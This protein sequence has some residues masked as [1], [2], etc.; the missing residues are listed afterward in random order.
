MAY[1]GAALSAEGSGD[2]LHLEAEPGFT[3]S[4]AG[5][6]GTS[7]G[8][9][10]FDRH[11]AMTWDHDLAGPGNVALMG[12]LGATTGTLALAFATTR[13]GATT[14]ARSALVVGLPEV[15][16]AALSGWTN[17][18][19]ELRLPSDALPANLAAQA[20]RAAAVLKAHE[21]R[22][23]PGAIVA[24]L[25]I[26]WGNAHDDLGGYHLV[27]ARDAVNSGLG[28]LA[29][30][31]TEDA[32]RMLSYLVAMQQLDGHWGQNFY[33]DG[34][35]Y[36][37]GIQMDEVG[38]PVILATKLLEAGLI[39]PDGPMH[40]HVQRM[41]ERATGFI[42]R[43]GPLTEQDRWEEN[44]GLNCYSLSVQV[45][46]LVAA[47]QW[48]SGA[49]RDLALAMADDWNARMED[50]TF[51]SG[52][53]LDRA[54]DIAG[55]YVRIV[56]DGRSPP[57]GQQVEVRNRGGLVTSVEDLVALDFLSLA[58]F[59]LRPSD[60]P[61]LRDTVKLCDALLGVDTPGGHSFYRYNGDG[62][63]EHANG[64]PFDG[65]GIG[66]AWPLLTGE[67]GHFAMQ[68]GED[69]KP[70]LSAMASMTGPGGLIPEQVWEA[71]ALPDRGLRPGKP[72]GA[73]M[74]LV[75]AHSEYL[76]LAAAACTGKP[77][78]LL[79]CVA[80]RYGTI[81]PDPNTRYWRDPTPLRQILQGTRLCVMDR[82]PFAL[83]ASEDDWRTT[84]D[85]E[86]EALPFGIFGATVEI[87][88][89][90]T[91]L[92]F[93]RRRQDGW[94]GRDHRVSIQPRT[95]EG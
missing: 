59:G 78:E 8:W 44:A 13:E 50:W 19:T 3:R 24:S 29:T 87:S 60:D 62:Y 48:L 53:S 64:A 37:R 2:W 81:R 5:F 66:R 85:L 51:V 11:G 74:P 1:A 4:S 26:P 45:T 47:G 68:A 20:H 39:P 36:W 21:D 79:D 54:H 25:S 31:Q 92:I 91:E 43:N 95:T 58:R 49:P 46:A 34:R 80:L 6:V 40:D 52:T 84:S 28:L 30:G 33:P 22:T 17:W 32:R 75:W 41:V 18:A 71:P 12:E 63:G 7:D 61:R 9:Q 72:T 73:A 89:G 88:E 70:W 14:L 42:L 23:Y 94:E 57:A 38:L 27:W 83:H 16:A 86:A 56:P 82:G 10:D 69:P 77:V 55:H 35:P 67:R 76:R 90:A 65:Q 93:T 15:R